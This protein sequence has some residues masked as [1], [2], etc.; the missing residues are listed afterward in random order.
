[1]IIL[2]RSFARWSL[3]FLCAVS[4]SCQSD[5]TEKED[6]EHQGLLFKTL[7]SDESG[8]DFVNKINESWDRNTLIF[9]YFYNGG[10]VAIGDINNDGLSDIYF[11]GNDSADKLYLNKGNLKFEDISNSALPPINKWSTGVNMVDI[12]NDGFLDIY[13]CTSGPFSAQ[14]TAALTNLLFVN[15]G[16]LTFTESAKEYGLDIHSRAIQSAFFDFDKD[17]DLDVWIGNHGE[18]STPDMMA[19]SMQMRE[20]GYDNVRHE[21][22][23]L[24]KN[25]NGV[26]E[27]FTAESYAFFVSFALGMAPADYNDDGNIDM[28]IANDYFVPDM[29]YLGQKNGKFTNKIKE[30]VD[31]TSFYSMG[32]DAAD[33]NNDGVLDLAVVDMTPSDHVRNKTL[34]ASMDAD[35]FRFMTE[36]LGFTKQFMF[37]SLQLGIGMGG[38]SEVG[39]M[40][41]VSQTEWSW[42]VLLAD[43]DNDG[44]KDYFVTNGFYRETKD[45][46]FKNRV[47]TYTDSTGVGYNKDVYDYFVKR[48]ASIPIQN[49]IFSNNQGEKYDDK[50]TEWLEDN[51][52]FS[53]GAAYADLDN[54]G[55]LDLVINNLM[56]EAVVMENLSKS[57]NWLQVDLKD[58]INPASVNFAKLFAYN[59]GEVQRVDYSFIRGYQSSVQP[60]AHFGLG[61]K[62]SVDSLVIKWMDN[63]KSVL[64]NIDANQKLVVDRNV[65]TKYYL[66]QLQRQDP[67]LDISF[68]IPNFQYLVH[69]ENVFN[70]F[71]KEVLLPHRYSDLGPALAIADVNNDGFD[72]FFLGGA[73]GS[74]GYIHIQSGKIFKPVKLP[75]F[76][77]DANYEDLGAEFFDV[78]NDGDLDLYVASGGGGDVELDASLRQD[79]IYLNQGNGLFERDEQRLPY[80]DASTKV[81]IPFDYDKDGDLDLFIGGR[82]SPGLYPLPSTS[83]LLENN[84]GYYKE[85]K[86]DW[87][88]DVPG[89]VT[90][91]EALDIDGDGR[92]DLVV[93]G[94]W[95]K[96]IFFQGTEKGMVKKE[97][98]L[99]E[100]YSGWWQSCTAVDID[101]DGDL[102]LVLGNLGENNKFHASPE[103]PLGVLASDFDMTG[104]HDIV[105]TK[106]YKGQEVLLR[107]KECSTEQMP[108]LNEKFK[109]Y[110]EFATSN[111]TE[112]LGA[113]EIE[114]AERFEVKSFS[115]I[116]L[117]N[118]GNFN[119]DISKLPFHAQ[120]APITT[121]LPDD[122]NNDG[123]IDLII[124]GAINN[125]EPE[126]VSYDAGKG[127]ILYGNGDFTFHDEF[128]M[129]KTGI[130]FNKNVRDFGYLKLG[131]RQ[132]GILVANNNNGL[133]MFL[134]N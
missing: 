102:D 24:A 32:A 15:N 43:F 26:Y 20:R 53:N 44:F 93:V 120:M 89:M 129:D 14:D 42:A 54:D 36:D 46:D 33:I 130:L 126:T 58:S 105:L 57:N 80:M 69:K 45:N 109:T 55:D 128:R 49:N 38:M 63:T 78:D 86:E 4:F 96:P 48:L 41:G 22:H 117:K 12:N 122:I 127:A 70:D 99:L 107:G 100:D 118:N 82:N 101:K 132:K 28:Y 111:I 16:D 40:M 94:E 67:F 110:K 2:S 8:I 23:Y 95:D 131:T 60:V 75:G 66:P 64:R 18:L 51:P 47:K 74:P 85:L 81:I 25:N 19:W 115:S 5:S 114:E 65:E 56:S 10:G 106:K 9:D 6:L 35:R 83:Y 62:E 30:L 79:R 71:K 104:T 116:I 97:M 98:P 73:M 125:T 34:M 37:N 134:K 112:I 3:I 88:K 123:H 92:L 31:H 133:Q 113:E 84:K 39:Q 27:D 13:V 50:S 59:N 119:F 108:F 91:G 68:K 77:K 11:T 1:M 121:C 72:D 76:E 90:G 7:S 52:S 21:G 17:G 29:L 61:S 124:G 87:L 103:K